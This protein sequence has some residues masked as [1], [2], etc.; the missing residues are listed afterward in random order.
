MSN[1]FF[2]R[3]TVRP[4]YNENNHIIKGLRSVHKIV[5]LNN[6]NIGPMIEILDAAKLH[7]CLAISVFVRLSLQTGY[8][9]DI[10]PCC[11]LHA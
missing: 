6:W 10:G 7:I 5:G 8:S 9:K 11:N 3:M 4:N 1:N 2:G